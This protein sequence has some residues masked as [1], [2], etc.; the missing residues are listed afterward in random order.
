MN[1]TV[2]SRTHVIGVVIKPHAMA[3][4]PDSSHN[5]RTALEA[6]GTA[7]AMIDNLHC[8]QGKLPQQVATRTLLAV[9][10][11]DDSGSRHKGTEIHYERV[12]WELWPADHER[13]RIKHAVLHRYADMIDQS[14]KLHTQRRTRTGSRPRMSSRPWPAFSAWARRARPQAFAVRKA[15]RQGAVASI[16]G[17]IDGHNGS[18]CRG[19]SDG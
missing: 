15:V 5:V 9:A 18:R 6:D 17:A 7:T 11:A 19:S 14:A 4:D 3:G 16:R 1:Q 2:R 12:E 10:C 13:I 8:V